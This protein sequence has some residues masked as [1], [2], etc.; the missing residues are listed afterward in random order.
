MYKVISILDKFSLKYEGVGGGG[1]GVRG[2]GGSNCPPPPGKLSS[3]S[4]VLLGLIVTVSV[5]K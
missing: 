5:E 1:G 2:G 3:K 4:P